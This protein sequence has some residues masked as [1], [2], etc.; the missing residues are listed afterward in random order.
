MYDLMQERIDDGSFWV[1]DNDYIIVQLDSMCERT[2]KP[3]SHFD[4]AL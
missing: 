2:S 4:R 1:D 3:T